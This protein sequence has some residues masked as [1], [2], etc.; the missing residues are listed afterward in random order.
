VT[1][2]KGSLYQPTWLRRARGL[3]K[4]GRALW[5]DDYTIRLAHPPDILIYSEDETMDIENAYYDN[6]G[7]AVENGTKVNEDSSLTPNQFLKSVSDIMKSRET[8]SEAAGKAGGGYP[9]DAYILEQMRL[10]A[11]DGE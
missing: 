10:I 8:N 3:V 6:D 11:G 2:E 5:V 1:D 7:N 9:G 4:N